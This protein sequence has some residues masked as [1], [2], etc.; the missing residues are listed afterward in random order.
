MAGSVSGMAS[1][2][3][4]YP[5]DVL[6]TKLQA[7]AAAT[8][9][10]AVLRQTLQF[11]GVGALY[12]GA[13]LPLLA[14]ALYKGTIFS[15]HAVTA[16]WVR[17]FKVMELQKLGQWPFAHDAAADDD[18][19]HH[20]HHH[21]LPLDYTD[22]AICGF[23]AGAV[24]AGAFVTPVELVRNQVRLFVC[25]VCEMKEL[26]WVDSYVGCNDDWQEWYLSSPF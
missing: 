21:K 9:P 16:E 13:T 19:D 6:R 14:Q 8:G 26:G 11:G 20:H 18:D 17:D 15:V 22:T 2:V 5:L 24:N 7:Q 25:S 1:T 23:V 4:L 12:T 10:L 3:V